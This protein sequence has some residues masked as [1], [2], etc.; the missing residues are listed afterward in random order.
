AR[1]SP[2]GVFELT[3][4]TRTSPIATFASA[5]G[6]VANT[7]VPSPGSGA[8]ES[9]SAVVSCFVVGNGI[10]VAWS[11]VSVQLCAARTGN[12]SWHFDA[13]AT[14]HTVPFR[15]AR[16]QR[17]KPGRPHVESESAWA[18]AARHAR[19]KPA[20]PRASAT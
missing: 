19:G 2:A 11:H 18:R 16:R 12:G 9:R 10:A 5:A 8:R 17:T 4:A 3:P 13:F 6:A 14:E 7:S 1:R 20:V 15:V